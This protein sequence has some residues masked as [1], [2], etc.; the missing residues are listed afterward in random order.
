MMK[1]RAAFTMLELIFVIVVMGFLGTYGVEFLA[2]AYSNF[3]FTKVNDDLQ[4]R[5]ET[6]VEFIAKRLEFRIKKSSRAINTTA[7][8]WNYIHGGISDDNADVLE[9]IAADDDGFRGT[10]FPLWSG[11]IDLTSSTNNA[12]VSPGSDFGGVSA[13]ISNLSDSTLN[14]SA[15]YFIDSKFS[16]TNPWGYNGAIANQDETLHPIQTTGVNDTLAPN[17]SN[18]SGKEISEYY[19]LTWTANAVRLENYN[20][21]TK[22]GDLYFY[23]DYQPWQGEAYTSGKRV[24]LAEDISAFRFRSAGALIK[25]QVCAKSDLLKDENGEYALCKEKTVF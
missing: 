9:W 15:I 6:A 23:Y 11:V 7:G 19:K 13:L 8:T 4:S 12:L 2:R 21:A 5:S 3:I 25:I 20:N 1:K 14:D 24:L 16:F 10:T 18:F 17:G 22:M